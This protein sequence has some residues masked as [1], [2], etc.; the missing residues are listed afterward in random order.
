MNGVLVVCCRWSM[1][2]T[3]VDVDSME[4]IIQWNGLWKMNIDMCVDVGVY[5]YVC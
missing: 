2:Y 3:N 1:A 4:I 5:V